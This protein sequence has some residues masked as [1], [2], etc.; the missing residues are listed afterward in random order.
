MI[1][2][3]FALFLSL[4]L[5]WVPACHAQVRG[6]FEKHDVPLRGPW[7]A[8]GVL[9]YLGG[10]SLIPSVFIEMARVANWDILRVK[11][12]ALIGREA[13]SV[14]E[15]GYPKVYVAGASLG[16]WLA[17]VAASLDNIDGIIG[18]APSM[19]TDLLWQ[20]NELARRL[21]VAKTKRIA[22]FFFE[23][24][25]SEQVPRSET[26]RQALQDTRSAYLLVDRPPGLLGRWAGATGL[27]TRR[28]RDCLL[29]FMLSEEVQPG[30][31]QC[32]TNWGYAVGED[33]GFPAEAPK[34]LGEPF[35][36]Y[37]G[38]WQADNEDG[39]YAIL[40]PIEARAD[41]LVAR[42]GLSPEPREIKPPP[43]LDGKVPKPRESPRPPL[44]GELLF[45]RDQARGD[46]VAPLSGADVTV[47]IRPI[48]ET[49]L[50]L[51]VDRSV[52]SPFVLRRQSGG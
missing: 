29:R 6:E 10:Q 38:R 41:E 9:I 19:T 2:R 50:D 34:V 51:R 47:R 4:A 12:G 13:D 40:Q 43:S 46:L 23:D 17:L 31:V 22:V 14:R 37:S 39:A 45:R 15:N 25:P 44:L 35:R 32:A 7:A 16:G 11:D 20:R 18:I 52:L 5:A 48:S 27:F 24:D 49:E 30:E 33:I 28:Y 26:I 1:L 21:A 3:V 36:A 42:F 8:E